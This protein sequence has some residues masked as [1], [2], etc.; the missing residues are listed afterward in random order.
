MDA[1]KVDGKKAAWR[2]RRLLGRARIPFAVPDHLP[3]MAAFARLHNTDAPGAV[4]EVRHMLTHPKDPDEVY[5]HGKLL[6]DCWLAITQ[7]LGLSLL[8]WVGYNGAVEDVS[9]LDRWYGD[10]VPVPWTVGSS[11]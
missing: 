7:W 4:A 2:M 1:S 5:R 9:K 3:S 11:N 10:V 8:H 6:R